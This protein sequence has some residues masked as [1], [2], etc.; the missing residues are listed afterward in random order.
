MGNILTKSSPRRW[1]VLYFVN[2]IKISISF[3]TS[4]LVISHSVTFLLGYNTHTH[5]SVVVSLSLTLYIYIY[6]YITF[7]S[8]LSNYLSFSY[9]SVN[10]FISLTKFLST[11]FPYLLHSNHN[12]LV[13]PPSDLQVFI[14]SIITKPY[15]TVNADFLNSVSLSLSLSLSLRLPLSLSLSLSLSLL[16]SVHIG[17]PSR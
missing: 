5:L 12:I 1:Q 9:P 15:Y 11:P 2:V 7:C 17:H 13:G 6:I 3:L 16:T 4:V 10:L 14:I 8:Y